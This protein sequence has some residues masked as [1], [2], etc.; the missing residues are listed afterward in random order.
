MEENILNE[1]E[2]NLLDEALNELHGTDNNNVPLLPENSKTLLIDN[3]VSRFSSAQWFDIIKTKYVVIGGCGGISSWLALLIARCHPYQIEI[4]DFDDVEEVNLAG[5][6][7]P[8]THVSVKKVNSIAHTINQYASY[9]NIITRCIRFT[10][11]TFGNNIMMCG[12][13]NMQAR[14]DFFQ[15]WQNYNNIIDEENRK[16]SLFIDGRL[17]AESFQIFCITGDDTYNIERYKNEFLFSSEEAEESVC[18][19]KQTSYCASMIASY[20]TNLFVNFCA[21]EAGDYRELPFFTAY[22]AKLMYLKVES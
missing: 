4:F 21:N 22:D 14:K 18:S 5:Q 13:D 12:F 7:F 11:S 1:E 3:T 2:Q 16:K 20:M 15:S 10:E 17:D 6:L 19:Y 8:R 9:Y